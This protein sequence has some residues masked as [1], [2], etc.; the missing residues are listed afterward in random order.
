MQLEKGLRK[1]FKWLVERCDDS[2]VSKTRLNAMAHSK[3]S[4][5]AEKSNMP[6][7]NF[8]VSAPSQLGILAPPSLL[9]TTP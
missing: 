9:F 4:M 5:F 7:Q 6:R 1:D 8:S 3:A 2:E